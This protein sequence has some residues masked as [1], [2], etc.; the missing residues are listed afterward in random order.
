MQILEKT[1]TKLAI[2]SSPIGLWFLAASIPVLG[3]LFVI[4][5]ILQSQPLSDKLFSLILITV[6]I[7]LATRASLDFAKNVQCTLDKRLNIVTIEERGLFKTKIILRSLSEVKDVLVSK[8]NNDRVPF[9]PVSLLF[10]SGEKLPIYLQLDFD[11][12]REKARITAEIVRHFLNLN[13]SIVTT[14]EPLAIG[15]EEI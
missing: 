12:D 1:S 4:D 6:W 13:R 7:G 9:Q 10:S 11:S 3:C 14:R 2:D 8:E 5:L 15:T